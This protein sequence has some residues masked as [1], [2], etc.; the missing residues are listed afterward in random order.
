MRV[1]TGHALKTV[2]IHACEKKGHA[3]ENVIMRVKT[4]NSLENN[5]QNSPVVSNSQTR[6]MSRR[7]HRP[8][9]F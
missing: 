1:K 5:L 4:V 3:T 8:V 2:I 9:Y 6:V 7:F